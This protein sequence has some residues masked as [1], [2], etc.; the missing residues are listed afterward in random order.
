MFKKVLMVICI[1]LSLFGRYRQG[2]TVSYIRDYK[3]VCY[4]RAVWSTVSKSTCSI[5]GSRELVCSVCGNVLDTGKI[6]CKHCKTEWFNEKISDCINGGKKV[7]R[8]VDCGKEYARVSVSKL[9]H[10]YADCRCIRC[11]SLSYVDD[12]SGTII[13]TQD[14]CETL[15]IRREVAV[16]IPETV[17]YYGKEYRVVGLGSSMFYNCSGITSIVMP[18]SIIYVGSHAFDYCTGMMSCKLSKNL[19]TI[20]QAAFQ[21]CFKLRHVDMPDSVEYI[22]NYAFN[23]CESLDESSFRIPS[24]L[25]HIGLNDKYPAHMFYDCGNK[26]FKGFTGGN[27]RYTPIDGILYARGGKT[28]VSIPVGKEFSDGTYTMPNSVETVGELS[29]SRNKNIQRLVISNKLV[30]DRE[31]TTDE[32]WSYLNYGNPLSIACYVYGN[33][34]EYLVRE[35]NLRYVSIEGILYTKDMRKVIAIPSQY[36]GSIVIPDGVTEWGSE[37]LWSCVEEFQNLAFGGISG[38]SIPKSLV[39]IAPDQVSA[40]NSLHKC[41]GTTINVDNGNPRYY[42]T[43]SGFLKEKE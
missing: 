17:N 26:S 21:C 11:G 2:D 3:H 32:K 28:L 37:S 39:N 27:D 30:V 40:V 25:K 7:L 16:V 1:G 38:I 34:G 5:E 22:G 19:R 20:E 9:G 23:H 33:V 24:S 6:L 43:A 12:K 4:E 29:F 35:D 10:E 41:F 8:C 42:V 36:K 18:D 15:G 31:L 13:L 14:M